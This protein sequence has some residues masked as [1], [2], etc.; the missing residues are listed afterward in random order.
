MASKLVELILSLNAQGFVAGADQSRAAANKL[1]N[2]LRGI[3]QVAG[4]ALSFAGIGIG[5]VEIIKLA[6]SYGQMTGKL[7]LATQYSGDYAEVQDLLRNSARE[8][9]SDLGGTVDLYTKMSPALKGIGM[10]AQQSVGIITTINKAIGLSGAS[11]EA[12]SAALVQLGQGFGS[13]VLRGEE[14][15]SV[16]EQTPALAQAIADGLGVPLGALRQLGAEGKLTAET[17]AQ[18]LQKVADQVDSDF[19]KMPTT[20]GQAM[21][22]LRNEFMTFIGETDKASGGTSVLANVIMTVADEFRQAGTAV[23]VF[24]SVIKTMLVGL[25]ASY[26]ILKILGTGLA[27]YAA[28]AMEVIKGNFSGAKAIWQDLGK[29]I[30]AILSKPLS[31]NPVDWEEQKAQAVASGI[32]KREGLEKQL[33]AEVKKLEE[34]KAFEA[35]KASDNVAAK[36]KA[37]ID[38]RIADQQRLVE[39]VRKAWQDSL[40]EAEKYANA[41]KEKLQ[42]AT[43][44]R[45]AGKSSAFNTGLKGLS[46]EDQL[47]AKS[48]RMTDLQGQG[49]YEAARARMAAL[50]GDIKKYDAAAAVA[51]KRLKEALQLAQDIGDVTSIEDISNTLAKNQEAG[52]GLDNKKAA[53]AQAQ[54]ADQAK[55]LNDL[56]AQLEKLEKTARSIAVQAD[57]TQAEGAITGLKQKLDEIKD[58]TVTVTVNSVKSGGAADLPV[59]DLSSYGPGDPGIP[60]RAYGGPLPGFAPH[61]RADNVIYRGTPGE[62]LIQRPTVKQP[63]ARSF[64][65]DFNARGMAALADWQL[66][67][68]A[69]GGEL[70]GSAIDRLNIPR[71]SDTVSS[72]AVRAGGNTVN[73]SLDGNRY[74]M[75]ASDDVVA[76]LTAHMQRESLRKGKRR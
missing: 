11:S 1:S 26:R 2:E 54:A 58:K 74:A 36:D 7:K 69:F 15:N 53:E 18:A 62:F 10:N 43:D 50:E 57:I 44:F 41:A 30:D 19:S 51:E 21:T 73:L 42:K 5:A 24:S 34:L 49:N 40:S 76:K 14:L 39:A 38:A 72:N 52:A 68:H 25:E 65:Y 46:E 17:V 71:L 59:L 70:G 6:D 37:N 3:Q 4:Q 67:R 20:V 33:A 16:M 8:T 64:L 13:G 35:G 29:D 31:A 47:A 63:G 48:Q 9:R 55:L 45:D 23:L 61:D 27:A 60:A 75:T 22:V 12:A 56:Q 28:I 66:P 32:K